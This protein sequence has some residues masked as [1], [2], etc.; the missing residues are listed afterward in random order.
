MQVTGLKVSQFRNIRQ[1]EL[2]P[3]P[4]VNVIYGENGQGK[5]NLLEA[6][7][8]FTGAGSFRQSKLHEMIRIGET[9]S[10][11][12]L[13]FA[14]AQREQTGWMKLS[15]RKEVQFNRI[16]C[17]S[18]SEIA[19]HFYGVV[20]SPSDLDLIQGGPKYRRQF[21]DD[22]ISQLRPQYAEYLEGYRKVLEQRNSLLKEIL[23]QPSLQDT[24]FLWD[25]QLARLGTIISLYRK[26]Y[27]H[28]LGR[29]CQPLYQGLSGGKESF[30]LGYLSSAFENLDQLTSYTPE[31]VAL[32]QKK[33]ADE[34]ETDLRQGSTSVGIHR[35]D[36]DIQVNGL[37][38][39]VYGSQGQQRSSVLAMKFGEASMIRRITGEQ[40]VLLLDDVMS[41]LDP[42]RQAYILNHIKDTQ[43]FLTCCDPAGPLRM[44]EGKSFHIQNGALILEEQRGQE[45]GREEKEDVSVFGP[46]HGGGQ[47]DGDGDL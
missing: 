42:S 10:V 27:L 24:L 5:S 41:E 7:W 14:D 39:R 22:A 45:S 19:G 4:G 31:T 28:K 34:L 43:V 25:E 38:V 2:H 33:L 13:E 1:M 11:L 9:A 32:Y 37:S 16:P 40:P 12:E 8:L 3:C 18:Q 26:D 20:F 46:G 21:C 47:P 23:R 35:D 36:L 6:I 15:G 29:F 17:R 44:K 30:F